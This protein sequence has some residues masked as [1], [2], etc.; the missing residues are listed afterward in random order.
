MTSSIVAT[1][2]LAVTGRGRILKRF[3]L[4]AGIDAAGIVESSQDA[5]FKAGDAI[6]ANGGIDNSDIRT[7]LVPNVAR[8][9]LYT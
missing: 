1:N 2:A 7:T 6:L 8:G 3:P 4:N 5:R 9:A